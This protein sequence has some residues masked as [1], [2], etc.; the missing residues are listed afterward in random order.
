M[1]TER[2]HVGLVAPPWVA[3]PPPLYGGTEL[4]VDE[5]AR[6]LTVA[7]HVVDLFTTGDS[8]SPVRRHWLHPAAVGTTG[9]L[10][11]ELGHVQAAYEALAGCDV[12]HDHT[13]LGPLWAVAER[14]AT[15]VVA[16]NHS[17]FTPQLRTL[18]RTVARRAAVVAI[19]HHQRAT[20][21]DVPVATVIHHGID[22][23]DIPVG[24]GDGGYVLFLGRMHADKGVHRAIAVARAAGRT[25][26]IAAKIWEPVE[27]RYFTECVQPI[28]GADARYLGQ[29]GGREKLELL[30]AAE[31]LV[32]PI[33]WPEPFGLVMI[34]ALAAGTPILTFA[35][36][37]APEIV[38]HAVT[39]FLC[40]DEA[41]MVARL[42]SVDGID[43]AACR[44]A[45]E[46]RFST[47]RMVQDHVALYRRVIRKSRNASAAR[48]GDVIVLG[49]EGRM[50]E[51]A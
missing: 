13:V 23:D 38:D 28:L 2:L 41:D 12:I 45:A 9:A 39:G 36:G 14:V 19:S 49:D 48:D 15:P 1:E 42:A 34:E 20:A 32:N 25:L 6:G 3:V 35:E 31:A 43:R 44:R 7:G 21:P 26:L 30:G 16:T 51:P 11:D 10:V 22:V 37:S 50:P 33:R 46:E 17:D 18:Y 27:Q 24:R 5:L 4:V 47:Q 8:T 40:T 29:V